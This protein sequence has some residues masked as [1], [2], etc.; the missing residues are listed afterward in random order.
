MKKAYASY[1][2]RGETLKMIEQADKIIEEYIA[3]GHNLTLRQLF[4]QHV[5]R[6]L[7]PN[8]ERSYKRLGSIINDARL[9]GMID[10]NAV[11][12]RTRDIVTNSHWGSPADILDVCAKQYAIDKW[13][14]QPKY[15]EV[16]VEK[17]ALIGVIEGVARELDVTCFSCRGYSSQSAMW[18]AALRMVRAEQRDKETIIFYLGDHDPSGINMTSDIRSRI[19]MFG[20]RTE[21]NRIAL[22]MDQIREVN[23]PPNPAKQALTLGTRLPTPGGWTTMGK[24]RVGDWLFGVDGKP[25]PVI[26]K[27]KVFPK[28]PCFRFTFACGGSI[29]C[30]E[31]HLWE[32]TARKR[33]SGVMPAAHIAE[34]WA[35]GLDRR[36]VYKIRVAD[37][38]DLPDVDL[39]I[40]PYVLG[41]WLGDGS[42]SGEG[43]A[44]GGHDDELLAHIEEEGFRTRR[45][46]NSPTSCTIYGLRGKLYRLGVANNKHIPLIY[47]RAGYVQHLALLQGLMDTDG[48]VGQNRSMTPCAFGSSRRVLAN[49]VLELLSTLGI[50][51]NMSESRA[52]LNGRDYGPTWKVEF[53]PGDLDVFRLSRKRKIL[54]GTHAAERQHW[55]TIIDVRR[56]AP[57][58]TQCISIASPDRLYLVGE[59]FIPTH[60]TDSRIKEYEAKYG[61][62]CWELDALEPSYIEDLVRDKVYEVRNADLWEE[63]TRRE[64]REREALK[65]LIKRLEE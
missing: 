45:R 58:E 24:V 50:R 51:G 34:T 21:V 19:M 11:E 56:V 31:D 48:T 5:A 63:M 1:N 57:R 26:A 46:S 4:Y 17:D 53:Y 35:E 52:V 25:Y 2:F 41:A 3:K 14:N 43:Y 18:R 39:P 54:V 29:V 9:A 27:S 60:N 28:R 47:L 33:R 6:G 61:N 8:T 64:A 40:P 10:W 38:L 15:V 59:H 36:P 7:I 12:D 42:S 20:A 44:C 30:S 32:V 13:Q 16:W 49:Q 65:G 23:P 22:T 37:P 62:E 55:R